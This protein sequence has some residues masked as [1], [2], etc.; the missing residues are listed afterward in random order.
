MACG[1]RSFKK[2]KTIEEKGTK[3]ILKRNTITDEKDCSR[4]R[5]RKTKKKEMSID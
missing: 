4:E 5:K 2:E 1:G 3:H